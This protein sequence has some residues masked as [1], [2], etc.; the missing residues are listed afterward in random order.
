MDA[1]M[2][3]GLRWLSMEHDASF[4]YDD[5]IV[6]PLGVDVVEVQH[7]QEYDGY[8]VHAGGDIGWKIGAGFRGHTSVGLS[9]LRGEV[10]Y[11]W[12]ER[13]PDDGVVNVD[14]TEEYDQSAFGAE[15]A[16]GITWSRTVSD[17]AAIGISLSY[18]ASW[19]PELIRGRRSA[20]D[21][22]EAVLLRTEEDLYLQGVALGVEVSF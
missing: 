21:V 3:V 2:R 5:A 20:D 9:F 15:F 14:L 19:W 12:V 11:D 8:G 17:S 18:D 22:T 13:E 4:H 6:D 16:L 7:E 1:R 10:D